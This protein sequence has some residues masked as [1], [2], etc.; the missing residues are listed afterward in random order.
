M[1][2]AD[3]QTRTES[4]S[5]S[6]RY[7]PNHAFSSTALSHGLLGLQARRRYGGAEGTTDTVQQPEL[8]GTRRKCGARDVVELVECLHKAM[9]LISSTKKSQV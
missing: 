7:I 3:T 4:T 1:S 5:F 9:G 8:A 2:R 6:V